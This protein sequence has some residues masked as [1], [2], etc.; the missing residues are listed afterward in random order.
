MRAVGAVG[1]LSDR[2]STRVCVS[3]GLNVN[4]RADVMVWT[5]RADNDFA[6]EI[7]SHLVLETAR[8]IDEGLSPDAAKAVARQRFGSVA[9]ARERFYE[10]HRWLWWDHL[11]Q[12][13]RAASRSVRRYPL[14]ALVAVLSL[15]SGIGATTITL[16]VRDVIFH[17]PPPAY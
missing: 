8:L 9:V 11:R 4:R 6:D 13:I 16:I 3:F 17:K 2:H 12:D 1:S 5:R 14:S 10:S 7:Q 15:G